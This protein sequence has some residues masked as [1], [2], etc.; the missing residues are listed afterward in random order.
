MYI[1]LLILF[2]GL[3]VGFV[4]G[5]MFMSYFNV[6]ILKKEMNEKYI[7]PMNELM[8]RGGGIYE[9]DYRYDNSVIIIF[10]ETK[11]IY[12]N[13]KERT[14]SILEGSDVLNTTIDGYSI[15]EEFF[16]G[17]ETLFHY[18]IYEDVKILYDTNNKIIVSNNIYEKFSK[19]NGENDNNY[20][21]KDVIIHDYIIDDILDKISSKGINSLSV[22]EIEFLKRQK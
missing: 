6:Y 16:D 21:D 2:C 18:E 1:I 3:L 20:D 17:L 9:F 11:K 13:L 7:K 19:N 14:F 5:I 15:Y 22:E 8:E 12:M 10:D 4:C